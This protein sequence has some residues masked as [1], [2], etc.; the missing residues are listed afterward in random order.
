VPADDPAPKRAG[1]QDCDV[2]HPQSL[3][4]PS[5]SPP[6]GAAF[7]RKDL[8]AYQAQS[9]SIQTQAERRAGCTW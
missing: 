5:C 6:D 8:V 9:R 3:T 2:P 4:S 1:S 7:K